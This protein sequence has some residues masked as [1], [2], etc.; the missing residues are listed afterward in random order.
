MKVCNRGNSQRWWTKPTGDGYEYIKIY[1]TNKV[2][3]SNTKHGFI[4]TIP[5]NGSQYQN[6]KFTNTASGFTMK[7]RVTGR[8]IVGK[9]I[10]NDKTPE[11]DCPVIN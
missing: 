10:L 4:Y 11:F 1:D 5:E 7:N 8:Q 9:W 3:D 2:I 6:W